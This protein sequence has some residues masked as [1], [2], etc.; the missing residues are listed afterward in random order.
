MGRPARATLNGVLVQALVLPRLVADEDQEEVRPTAEGVGTLYQL[1]A[2]VE[3]Y[4][5]ARP[6]ECSA[7]ESDLLVRVIRASLEVADALGADFV[8]LLRDGLEATLRSLWQQSNESANEDK[9]FAL[10][11]LGRGDQSPSSGACR[12][13]GCTVVDDARR[14]FRHTNCTR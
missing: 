7:V 13:Y 6:A 2:A 11:Q 10:H 9:R 4:R 1:D 12:R 14:R 3:A 8:V 5:E